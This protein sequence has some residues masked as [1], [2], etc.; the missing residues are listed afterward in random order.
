MPLRTTNHEH[1][2]A[3]KGR[4]AAINPE[5]RFEQ[6]AREACDDGWDTP[7]P[8]DGVPPLRTHVTIEH[9]KSIK[10]GRAHV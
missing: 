10:I 2:T 4:G 5:G 7:P 9:A 1:A 6:T 3:R 8:A